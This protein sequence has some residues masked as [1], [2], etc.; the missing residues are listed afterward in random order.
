MPSPRGNLRPMD[1]FEAARNG[2]IEE[3]EA[4][5][6]RGQDLGQPDESGR[7]ALL[8][9]AEHGHASVVT[10]LLASGADPNADGAGVR[11]L[12]VALEHEHWDVAAALVRRGADP[13]ADGVASIVLAAPP[14]RQLLALMLKHGLD[15]NG[16]HPDFGP[17]VQFA[18]NDA[19]CCDMLLAAGFDLA[20]YE[21]E[22]GESLLERALLTD[23]ARFEQLLKLRADVNLPIDRRTRR[24]LL[25]HLAEEEPTE[26][27]HE[28]IRT[29]AKRGGDI[30]QP[31]AEGR[32]AIDI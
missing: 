6:A 10:L 22:V 32:T 31:D 27:V 7:T 26:E 11:P 25:M 13:N 15:P 17:Y 16:A 3:L 4:H 29:I 30:E 14:K 20:R 9:A 28:L 24:T 21:R 8:V 1:W 23:R 5:L 12:K 18:L 19:A 2:V